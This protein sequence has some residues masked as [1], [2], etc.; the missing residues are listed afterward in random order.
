MGRQLSLFDDTLEDEFQSL[1]RHIP[2]A[3]AD[4]ASH[5]LHA[6]PAKFL[7]HYPGVFIRHFSKEGDLVLDP[8]CGAGTTVIE[9]CLQD[10][11]AYGLDID[12]IAALTARVS[13][14][15]IPEQDL[16]AFENRV[17]D[18]I[19]IRLSEG[20]ASRVELPSEQEFPNIDIWFREPVLRELLVAR[21]VILDSGASEALVDFGLVC[22]SSIVKPVSNADPRDIFPERDLDNPVRERKDVVTELRKAFHDNR[23]RLIEFSHRVNW[24][25]RG[26]VRR[27]NATAMQ[28]DDT[29][30]DLI[31][32]S[33]PYAYAMDYARVHKLS[34]LLI[35]MSNEEF[36]EYRRQYVGTDR[37]SVKH[38]LESFEGFEFAEDQ[39]RRVHADRRKLGV[40]LHRY[41]SDLY[42]ITRECNRVLKPGGHLIYVIGNSTVRGTTFRT[43]QVL[44]G[45]CEGVG[46]RTKR[47]LERPY[48][49]YRMAR[50]RNVQSNTIKADI[51]LVT[52]KTES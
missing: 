8:M 11:R 10:R 31:F 44:A 9:A 47:R 14:T 32:T 21:D 19:R 50:K 18:E 52:G 20:C 3:E 37:V 42:Q 13:T 7:P 30:V 39:I 36:L 33:P 49:A 27:G 26:K 22:L 41:F 51:F 34:T 2:S 1:M 16:R 12:P 17:F 24:E 48:Y 23:V 40:I 46:L 4:Y 45:I 28:L 43:D 5:G 6:Y 35:V 25:T 38:P 29:S 15:P